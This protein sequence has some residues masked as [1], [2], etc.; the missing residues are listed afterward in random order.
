MLLLR[1]VIGFM[2]SSYEGRVIQVAVLYEN[3]TTLSI[4]SLATRRDT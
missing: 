2:K 1:D 4:L 3:Y